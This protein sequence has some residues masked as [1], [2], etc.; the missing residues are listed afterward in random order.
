VH[1]RVGDRRIRTLRRGS[2]GRTI[3]VRGLPQR[4][5]AVRVTVVAAEGRRTFVGRYRRCG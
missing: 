4:R 2:L 1:V 5:V 3:V